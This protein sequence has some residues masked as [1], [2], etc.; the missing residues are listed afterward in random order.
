MDPSALPFDTE[1]MLQGLRE[2]AGCESP[3]LDAGARIGRAAAR[4]HRGRLVAGLSA[5]FG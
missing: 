5:D 3:D 1:T 4:T 2:R